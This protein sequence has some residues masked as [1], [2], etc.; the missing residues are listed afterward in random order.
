VCPRDS[1]RCGASKRDNPVFLS[2]NLHN[3][4]L[5]VL[6]S[7]SIELIF[8]GVRHVIMPQDKTVTP[9]D[10]TVDSSLIDVFIGTDQ[11]EVDGLTLAQLSKSCLRLRPT[12]DHKESSNTG[13]FTFGC[14]MVEPPSVRFTCATVTL[15]VH[16]HTEG[17]FSL[18][19]G[20]LLTNWVG[21]RRSQLI[22]QDLNNR[23][24]IDLTNSL[25][26]N[27]GGVFMGDGCL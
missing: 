12:T 3:E 15:R 8:F 7:L 9:L 21:A 13:K 5:M 16:N 18:I 19:R 1:I 14:Q 24:R 2:Q 20:E 26:K 22:S 10:P 23:I 4:A 11:S 27:C 17:I 25:E 6:S